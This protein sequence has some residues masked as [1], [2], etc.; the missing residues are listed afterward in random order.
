MDNNKKIVVRQAELRDA[1]AL[2][3]IYTQPR[4]FAAAGSL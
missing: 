2:R 3:E 1:A 4:A